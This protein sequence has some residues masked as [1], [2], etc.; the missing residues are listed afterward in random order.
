MAPLIYQFEEQEDQ[1]AAVLPLELPDSAL[2]SGSYLHAQGADINPLSLFYTPFSIRC[3]ITLHQIC[4]RE[5]LTGIP[6]RL[7]ERQKPVPE[8]QRIFLSPPTCL[9]TWLKVDK[10]SRI[11]TRTTPA[12]LGLPHDIFISENKSPPCPMDNDN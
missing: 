1:T 7:Q 2:L 4:G 12:P 9:V 6:A 3:I 10:S 5:K 8:I 11:R